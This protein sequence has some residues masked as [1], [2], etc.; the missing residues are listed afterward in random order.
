M[1][2]ALL[3]Q[4][5]KSDYWIVDSRRLIVDEDFIEREDYGDIDAIVQW[6]KANGIQNLNPLKCYKRGED[7]II[8]RGHRRNKAIQKLAT[9]TG[10]P[11]M[12][13][14]MLVK[15][16]DSEERQYFEQ[17]T[18]NDSKVYTPWEKAKVLKRVRNLFGWSE[19]KMVEESG[20]SLVYVKRLLS[21]AD[22]PE[23]LI[24]LVRQGRVKGTFAMD[25]IA[26]GRVQ[27]VIDKAEQNALPAPDTELD[28]FPGNGGEVVPPKA[29]KITRSDLKPNSWKAFRKW[30]PQVE[31]KHLDP[32]KAKFLKWL[33]RMMEGEL[34]EEDF[35]KFFR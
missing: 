20:W 5:K 24:Q 4:D 13:P 22:A 2:K 26:E 10:E 34:T 11:L 32:E 1:A 18:E 23:K 25:M 9:I 33:K 35:K 29:E 8:R 27:E 7:Y 6:I 19:E 30:V 12:V 28:L 17:A 16:G 31:E 14:I 15:K 21:L 3:A